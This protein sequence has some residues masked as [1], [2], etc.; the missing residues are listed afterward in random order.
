VSQVLEKKALEKAQKENNIATK[1][2]VKEFDVEKLKPF[3]IQFED[4]VQ[5]I[6]ELDLCNNILLFV[7]V[8]SGLSLVFLFGIGVA[9][10]TSL[11]S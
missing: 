9:K 4:P 11:A 8:I 1:R 7:M 6:T 10:L 5:E 2:K 3:F